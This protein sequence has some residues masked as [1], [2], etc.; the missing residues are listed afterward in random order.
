[1]NSKMSNEN[2]ENLKEWEE[3]QKRIGSAENGQETKAPSENLK[4]DALKDI[5][6][7]NTD[8]GVAWSFL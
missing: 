2:Y 8:K 3:N 4:E 1:M 6:I 5:D 7:E